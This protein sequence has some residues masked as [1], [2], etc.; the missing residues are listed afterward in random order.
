MC[1]HMKRSAIVVP[2][3]APAVS[4]TVLEIGEGK[5]R[6]HTATLRI[7]WA[8]E[9]VAFQNIPKAYDACNDTALILQV[10][11]PNHKKESRQ[12]HTKLQ[13]KRNL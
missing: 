3:V 12:E 13:A 10:R 6:I 7:D 2:V 1:V 11:I 5:E 8:D 9:L 4:R